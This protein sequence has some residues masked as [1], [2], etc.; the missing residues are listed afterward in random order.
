[1][2]RKGLAG[3]IAPLGF[4]GIAEWECLA[5]RED[6]SDSCGEG[7]RLSRWI[8]GSY[9]S[10]PVLVLDLAGLDIFLEG[11]GF[12]ERE[13]LVEGEDLERGRRRVRLSRWIVRN[14]RPAPAL[15]LAPGRGFVELTSWD[16]GLGVLEQV[17][18]DVGLGTVKTGWVD[19]LGTAV[20]AARADGLGTVD[21]E[22]AVGVGVGLCIIR[23][24]K[25]QKIPN[26]IREDRER[27]QEYP[28]R[29]YQELG[30]WVLWGNKE[31]GPAV[32]ESA[33]DPLRV[34]VQL[35][36]QVPVDAARSVVVPA[37][38][39]EYVGSGR[40]VKMNLDFSAEGSNSVSGT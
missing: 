12:V 40:T 13:S 19:G 2:K 31:L 11:E 38:Y 28:T 39:Q 32:L 16:V 24:Q 14:F 35:G 6:L 21:A 4:V 10:A 17:G 15:V 3:S 1:M 25:G 29:E 9:H 26:W 20:T 22:E 36:I 34:P 37:V 5:E 33:D 30:Q 27:N 18:R 7:Y 23:E 8:V